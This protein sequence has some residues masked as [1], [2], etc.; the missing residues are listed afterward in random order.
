MPT[1]YYA[2][3]IAITYGDRPGEPAL[4]SAKWPVLQDRI[5]G[6]C[7]AAIVA[8]IAILMTTVEESAWMLTTYVAG[9]VF[10]LVY[11]VAWSVGPSAFIPSRVLLARR[12]AG[13]RFAP[14]RFE[15]WLTGFT[16][17]L[18]LLWG[19][20]AVWWIAAALR[21]DVPLSSLPKLMFVTAA[22]GIFALVRTVKLMPA[23]WSRSTGLR[24]STDG[25]FMSWEGKSR[26]LRWS[27]LW[28]ATIEPQKRTGPKLA[29]WRRGSAMPIAIDA[30]GLGSDPMV[31]AAL[32]HYYRDHP[33]DRHLLDH[34]EA[35]FEKFR[36]G[37]V[38]T[39]PNTDGEIL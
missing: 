27:E 33:E 1:K 22:L 10:A 21:H 2:S 3:R 36:V 37:M 29:L 12:A 38:A 11:L 7:F 13:L 31:V 24:I 34:P 28:R 16:M 23:L 39:R 9:G 17:G 18:L 35:A 8:V 19:S 15:Y 4:V 20:A 26:Q 5:I 14:N 25:I 30:R 32:I 6:S